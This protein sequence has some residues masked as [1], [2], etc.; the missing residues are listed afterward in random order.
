MVCGVIL[1][2]EPYR[3]KKIY[4]YFLLSFKKTSENILIVQRQN[5]NNNKF[6]HRRKIRMRID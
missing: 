5:N 2:K 6:I 1:G 4:V 3:F